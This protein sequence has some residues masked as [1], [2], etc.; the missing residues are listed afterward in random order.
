MKKILSILLLFTFSLPLFAQSKDEAVFGTEVTYYVENYKGGS[1]APSM[2]FCQDE[3]T[4]QYYHLSSFDNDSDSCLVFYT[5]TIENT[6]ILYNKINDH[7]VKADSSLNVEIVDAKNRK[8]RLFAAEE[9]R[10][11]TLVR[12]QEIG[13]DKWAIISEN[14]IRNFQRVFPEDE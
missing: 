13:S 4:K 10:L 8:F 7:I 1:Y 12:I 9:K 2:Y 5:G 3:K 11:G 14:H 6:K